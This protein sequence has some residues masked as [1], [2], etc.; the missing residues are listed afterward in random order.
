MSLIDVTTKYA[1]CSARMN[2][3]IQYV[4]SVKA[5]NGIDIEKKASE[6][7]SSENTEATD[8]QNSDEQNRNVE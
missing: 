7:G 2:A 4:D 3:V 6:T 5:V 1:I 8:N